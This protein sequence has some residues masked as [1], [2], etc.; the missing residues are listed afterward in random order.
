MTVRYLN[1]GTNTWNRV[2]FPNYSLASQAPLSNL[3]WGPAR[4]GL[5]S[6]IPPGGEALFTFDVTAPALDGVYNLQFQ[7]I[8]DGVE[9]FG[10]L[11]PNVA[12][13]VTTPVN[14]AAAA[15]QSV[16]S[17]MLLGQ[18]YSVS[19]AFTNTGNT[20][21]T[22]AGGYAAVSLNP[23]N[24][25]NWGTN[26][27]ALAAPVP[28]GGVASF[29]FSVTA[30]AAPAVLNYQW[31]MAR[32]GN[33]FGA[34]SPLQVVSV[35]APTNAATFA[36]QSFPLTVRT[37]A[38]A[39]AEIRLRN[40]GNLPW[41]DADGYHLKSQNP[42]GGSAWGTN[43]M[44]LIAP[45]LPGQT[46]VFNA[47]LT[48]PLT[49]GP[50]NFQ[51]QM[52]RT[53]D[54]VFGEASSNL[55][56][57]VTAP[58]N[59]AAF[60]T[61]TVAAVMVTGRTENVS[62]TMRNTGDT[63]WTTAGGYALA[64][65][66]PAD[67]VVW[68]LSRAALPADT[69]PGLEAVF[70]FAVMPPMVAGVT[71]FQWQMVQAGA[72]VFGGPSSN[73]VVTVRTLVANAEFVSQTVPA[74]MLTGRVYNASVRFKNTGELTWDDA[75]GFRLASVIPGNDAIWGTNRIALGAP[76][77]PGATGTFAFAVSAPLVA[78]PYDFRW[79]MIRE[80]AG[81]FGA[82]GSNSV[83]TVA[84]PVNNAA[85][86]T[87]TVAS[88]MITGRTE[89]VSISMRNT[90][91]TT[92][93][94]AGGYALA[95]INPVDNTVWGGNRAV[96]TAD[97]VPGQ[98]AVFNFQAVA[99]MLPGTNNFQWRLFQNG[100][101]LFGEATANVAVNVRGLVTDAEFI[102]QTVPANMLTGRVYNAAV[103]FRNNGEVTWDPAQGFR[104][105]SVMGG[106]DAVWGTNRIALAAA[107]APGQTGTF[108]F[109]VSAPLAAGAYD[110]RWRMIREGA[111]LFGATGSN[112]IVN[113]TVPVNNAAF[114]TQTVAAAVVTG[115]V[116]NVSI[117][118][119]NTGDT[120]WT[121]AGGYALAAI[122]PVD[123]TFWGGN[124]ASLA[125]DTAPGQ[126]AVFNF[127]AG[128]PLNPGSYNFQWQMVQAGTGAFG[129]ASSNVIVT[130]RTPV[131]LAAFV[132]QT[133]PTNLVTGQTFNVSVTVRNTGD[134]TWPAGGI[135]RLA[136]R[137]PADNSTWGTN[138]V[139][140]SSTVAP[141]ALATFTFPLR[142][143]GVG[144]NYNHQWQMSQDGVGGFGDFT[145]N[146]VISVIGSIDAAAFVSQSV[147]S[148]MVGGQR[149][150]VSVTM[151]NT[152][153]TTWTQA[154]KYKLSAQNPVDNRS[155]G[156]YRILLPTSV[157]PG[158][159]V[160]FS[161]TVTAPATAGN[162]NFQWRMLREGTGWFG[163]TSPNLVIPVSAAPNNAAF[164][165]QT[166][167]TSMRAGTTN[168]VTVRMRNTGTQTWTAAANYR[169]GS[170]SPMDNSTWGLRRVVVPASVAPGADAVF[171][172]NV[173]APATA[174]SYVFAWKM[175]QEG[176]AWFGTNSP[177]TT[178]TISP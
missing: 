40:T 27:L 30:P 102:A 109:A 48:A 83:V 18:T 131:S 176:V 135:Y 16:P 10:D 122:N 167:P 113:V 70:T 174:G 106:N 130:V 141:G 87:Q 105:A 175:I 170:Q 23:A 1:V 92:W 97:T 55:V 41:T 59:N 107:V 137:N 34:A 140:L 136:S 36:G 95:A 26:R 71:N 11:T 76:V 3:T 9:L 96:L 173:K 84:V 94:T 156:D 90:G 138:R 177:N 152:G 72:G 155:W 4:R 126:E 127:I 159:T 153:S 118:M 31:Q 163:Q 65:V 68:G 147:P 2:G 148:S 145:P 164:V 28:P 64:A 5:S 80:G 60:V 45:V 13:Q 50:Q 124:R 54:G 43:R 78:G 22:D 161:W 73:V 172:F 139:T 150:T 29:A 104:L 117:T 149:Y 8:N 103:S 162:Y 37:G 39:A 129:S 134:T 93:T 52:A 154:A 121:T 57:V 128:A 168:S 123:N 112:A 74:G 79:Q 53:G 101:G 32:T 86:V 98:V 7:M 61:Q 35:E 25:L 38:V 85:F 116:Q 108:A 15:A 146:V 100:S 63:T 171:T 56:V 20:V 158:G 143:P 49:V 66:N 82:T 125:G 77:A 19:V 21:W 17:V 178:I 165:S 120:T 14:N 47:S 88:V 24:N 33:V 115:Q 42:E 166:V 160:T 12:V 119:R 142:A 91:D 114:V 44:N 99:P 81:L 157:L 62:I 46:G 110:F 133:V 89:N 151:R 58:V 67:N 169:L 69:A 132:S 51:W 75:Q 6:D 144:G 111:G